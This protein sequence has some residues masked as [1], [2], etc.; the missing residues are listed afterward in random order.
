MSPNLLSSWRKVGELKYLSSRK[1][2][3]NRDGL[4]SDE[5]NGHSPNLLLAVGV[6]GP[7]YFSAWLEEGFGKS[8]QR[9]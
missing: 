3:I 7:K 5:R 2:E 6:V 9:G 4:S 1:Q 8:R